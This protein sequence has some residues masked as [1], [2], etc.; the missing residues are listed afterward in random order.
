VIIPNGV[1]AAMMASVRG[2]DL[3]FLRGMDGFYMKNSNFS[4]FAIEHKSVTL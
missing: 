3:W 4:Q 2:H 1:T